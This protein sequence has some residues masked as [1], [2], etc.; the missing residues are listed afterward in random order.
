MNYFE[1][2]LPKENMNKVNDK[3]IIKKYEENNNIKFDIMN[4]NNNKELNN[5]IFS[6]GEI[7]T[8]INYYGEDFLIT[9]NILSQIKIYSLIKW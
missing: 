5:L 6:K 9:G 4:I 1:C 8:C 2:E 3:F 7:I